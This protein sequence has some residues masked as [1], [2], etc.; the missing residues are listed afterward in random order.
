MQYLYLMLRK[1]VINVRQENPKLFAVI[2]ELAHVDHLR[3]NIML[4]KKYLVVC[5]I[6][7][8]AKILLHLVARQHFVDGPDLYSLQDLLD[9]KSGKW[10]DQPL[11]GLPLP[12]GLNNCI[13][14]K[15]RFEPFR[16]GLQEVGDLLAS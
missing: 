15:N 2:Q 7:A 10:S 1:P 12:K 16:R 5:R 9:I 8:E 6:A 3:H 14:I 11:G 13:C 4:M